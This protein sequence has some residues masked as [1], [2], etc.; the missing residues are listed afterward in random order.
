MNL[1]NMLNL[2][3]SLA[4]RVAG[5]IFKTQS[6]RLED[7]KSVKQHVGSERSSTTNQFWGLVEEVG[8]GYFVVYR[9][10]WAPGL[11]A[12]VYNLR[13]S[14]NRSLDITDTIIVHSV[15][16]ETRRVYYT[17]FLNRKLNLGDALYPI[18]SNSGA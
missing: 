3:K 18:W 12:G 15:D 16:L 7:S 10:E 5:L 1:K 17:H 6:Y 8:D 2:G 9:H 14:V 13:M 11:W 4:A